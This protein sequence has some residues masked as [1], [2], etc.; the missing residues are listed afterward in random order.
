MNVA[1]RPAPSL[2]ITI[3]LVNQDSNV[4]NTA[5]FYAQ[6][7]VSLGMNSGYLRVL[8]YLNGEYSTCLVTAVFSFLQ[9]PYCI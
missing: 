1:I 8:I 4:Y 3:I 6:I 7:L 2:G 9:L 5:R